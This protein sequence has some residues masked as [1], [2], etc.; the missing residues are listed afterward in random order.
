MIQ[1]SI[2]FIELANQQTSL[3]GGRIHISN[4]NLNP[5]YSEYIHTHMNQLMYP[6]IYWYNQYMFNTIPVDPNM[7]SQYSPNDITAIQN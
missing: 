6:L 5:D 3:E 7:K 1:K 4:V 2:V